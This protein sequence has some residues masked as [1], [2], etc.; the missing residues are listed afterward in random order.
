MVYAI[1]VLFGI[2][3]AEIAMCLTVSDVQK[4]VFVLFFRCFKTFF[5]FYPHD[6]KFVKLKCIIVM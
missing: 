5:C 1:R 6:A 2:V 3:M 4:P